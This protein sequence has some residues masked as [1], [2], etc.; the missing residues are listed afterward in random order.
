MK[1]LT[2]FLV[3]LYLATTALW[4]YSF[5]SGE[6]YYNIKNSLSQEVEVTNNGT[7]SYYGSYWGNIEIPSI[8][9]FMGQPFTVTRIGDHAFSNSKGLTSITI[10]ES[11]WSIGEASFEGCTQLSSIVVDENN[12]SYDSRNNCNAIIETA[13]N[14]LVVGCQTTT[15][16]YGIVRI[17]D[18]AFYYCEELSSIFIPNSVTSIGFKAFMGCFDLS[19]VV[20]PNRLTDIGYAAF[21]GC[22]ELKVIYIKSPTPPQMSIPVDVIDGYYYLGVFSSSN[23]FEHIYIPCGTTEAYTSSNWG[24]FAQYFEEMCSTSGYE[25]S[26]ISA[27][28]L[29][30]KVNFIFDNSIGELNLSATANTYYQFSHWSDGKTDNPRV[31]TVT[32]D[33]TL[34]AYFGRIGHFAG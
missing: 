21:N 32:Q 17:G 25:I 31:L 3:A 5:K 29:K 20:I 26:V 13:T 9:Y 30:G 34:I 33:T 7:S 14:V 27:D 15:I 23:G 6:I 8:V 1:R 10:P 22:N 12:T 28:T 11:I 4:A 24:C 19:S 16:P 18:Y 2:S